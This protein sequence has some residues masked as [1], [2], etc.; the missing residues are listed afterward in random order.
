MSDPKDKKTNILMLIDKMSA[1]EVVNWSM[2]SFVA[3]CVMGIAGMAIA[4]AVLHTDW[5]V[6]GIAIFMATVDVSISL[7]LIWNYFNMQK[8]NLR[9]LKKFYERQKEKL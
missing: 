9:A 3:V 2:L 6:L 4:F 5:I 8:R 1:Y 7:A